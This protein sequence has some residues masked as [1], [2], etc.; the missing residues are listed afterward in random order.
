MFGVKNGIAWYDMRIAQA[1]RQQWRMSWRRQ[2]FHRDD[3]SAS[4]G[5]NNVGIARRRRKRRRNA[6]RSLSTMLLC[7]RRMFCLRASH[8]RGDN[9]QRNQAANDKASRVTLGKT[10]EISANEH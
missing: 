3:V 7:A 6:R 2:C 9:V 8:V 4:R 1:A 10:I 5:I